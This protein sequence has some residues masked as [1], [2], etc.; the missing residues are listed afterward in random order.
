MTIQNRVLIVGAPRSGTTLS[1]QIF[2]SHPDFY[3]TGETHYFQFLLRNDL[4][5]YIDKFIIPGSRCK[6]FIDYTRETG[7]L[8]I[9]ENID[10]PHNLRTSIDFFLTVMDY[11][12]ELN[13]KSAWLEKTPSHV[14]YI[15]RIESLDNTLKYIHIFRDPRSVAASL[16]SVGKKYPDQWPGY[17]S[18]DNVAREIESTYIESVKHINK[19]N[20]IFIEFDHFLSSAKTTIQKVL[21]HLDI[22]NNEQLINQMIDGFSD[23]NLW[24]KNEDWK[25]G[26]GDKLHSGS[27]SK[28]DSLDEG[29]KKQF[30][31]LENKSRYIYNELI[32]NE[33]MA[34]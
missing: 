11:N 23:K 8:S 17:D 29:I 18:I 26:Y 22:N 30:L 6:K 19:P 12:T 33:I 27:T 1:Q 9:P 34:R 16:L 28:F 25:T 14:R 20:H 15:D 32:K 31:L 13:N 4:R 24:D 10:K 7:I 21:N 2:S 3:S 5:R